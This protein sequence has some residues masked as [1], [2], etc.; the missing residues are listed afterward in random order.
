MNETYDLAVIGGGPSGASAAITAARAGAR[1]LL[2]DRD[3]FPRPKVCGEFVSAESLSLL[4]E[5]LGPEHPL[6]TTT[7]QISAGRL[8][9]AGSVTDT[10]IDPPARSIPRFEL[11]E[12]LWRAAENSGAD[13]RSD[14]AVAKME[15]DG[16]FVIHSAD[17]RYEARAVINAS[18]RWS[19]VLK[20]L[21]PPAGPKWIGLK[22]HYASP[23]AD[24]TV[25][26]Y[27][28]RHGYCGVQ[29]VG[30]GRLNVCAMVRSDVATT[31]EAVLERHPA[32]KMR[33]FEMQRLGEAV[34]TAP[35]LHAPPEPLHGNVLQVGDAAGFI[36]PFLGDGISMALQTGT[37]AALHLVPFFTRGCDL[38][39]AARHYASRY[40]SAIR[41]AFAHAARLRRILS[42]SQPFQ[43]AV[44][45]LLKI[46]HITEWFLKKTR[47]KAAGIS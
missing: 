38:A 23:A 43:P 8:F 4:T 16:P 1:T 19:G 37:S 25:D 40:D 22:A 34:V 32:L 41:P 45:G 6:L 29:P 27:F 9:I 28:F 46:P 47:P 7:P 21:E 18:G 30:P 2:L 39:T 42:V 26:L 33:S 10:H 12:A 11:D 36:D 3:T 15:G 24:T 44:T 13:T 31:L 5:L 17:Q 20:P 35:L 14:E